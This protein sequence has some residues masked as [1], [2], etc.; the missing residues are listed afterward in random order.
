MLDKLAEETS[1]RPYGVAAVGM[2]YLVFSNF[3]IIDNFPLLAAAESGEIYVQHQKGD[4]MSYL[5]YDEETSKL[6]IYIKCK[7][8]IEKPLLEKKPYVP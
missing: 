7:P 4:V 5:F 2:H 8:K 3:Q 6:G 1:W